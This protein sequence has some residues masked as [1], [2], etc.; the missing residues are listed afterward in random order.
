[1]TM[2]ALKTGLGV[3]L[4]AVLATTIAACGS[5]AAESTGSESTAS[6]AGPEIST[7]VVGVQ[8]FAELAPL[9]LAINEGIFEKHGLT[10]ELT[11]SAGGGAGLIPGMVAGDIDVVY[12]NYVSLIQGASKGL[13][14]QVI[15]ENDRPG[16]Q[17]VYVRPDSG[18]SGP[19]DLAGKTI[20]VNGLGNIMELT[21]RAVLESYDVTDAK[22]V[23]IPPP[24]M[25]AALASGQVD[26]A[27][28]VEPFV[29][30]ASG[31]LGAIPVVSAFEGPTEDLPVAGWAV[32]TAF[33]AKNPQTVEAFV[34]AMD[35][36][37]ALAVADDQA[38]KDTLLTY[39]KI[40]ENIVAKLK[41]ISFAEASDFS[42]LEKLM[43][44]MVDQELIDAP[45][46][47]ETFVLDITSR[48]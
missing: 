23:E 20:A 15:R 36:A 16:V 46:D 29:T 18:I 7:I 39:T 45:I 26:G 28:L 2:T 44:I 3:A 35:E 31:T 27:W 38:V 25:E 47:L 6:S 13:P 11:E 37:M 5:P 24:N 41:P 4:T 40:P 22:F 32:N 19:Q 12:S 14:L 1:M 10:V 42:N 33:A 21:A 43:A 9:H 8:P 34:G 30:I 17:A 48:K